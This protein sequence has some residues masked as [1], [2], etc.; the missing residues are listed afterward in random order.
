MSRQQHA[1]T[2]RG[3]VLRFHDLKARGIVRCWPTLLAWIKHEN[4]PAGFQLGPHSRAWLETDVI[5][6]LRSR[7]VAGEKVERQSEYANSY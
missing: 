1:A 3:T 6:W 4:F 5:A 7:P 2:E